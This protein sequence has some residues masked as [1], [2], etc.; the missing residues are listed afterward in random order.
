MTVAEA[1]SSRYRAPALEKGLQILE[2]LARTPRPLT[3][4]QLSES[5]ERSKGEIFRMVQVLEAS[6]YIA[7]RP[8]EEGYALTNRLFTLGMEQP[9]VRDLIGAA[10][11]L[12]QHLATEIQ[13]SCH[14][15]VASREQIVV[16][17]RVESPGEVGFAVRFGARRPLH[18]STSGHVLF[19]FQ[20]ATDQSAWLQMLRDH[21]PDL[22]EARLLAQAREIS[23]QGHARE[24]SAYIDGVTD[25]S[26]PL[27]A[28]RVA[29]AALTVPYVKRANEPSQIEQAA[30]ALS[31]TAEDI[32]HTL[33]FGNHAAITAR[34]TLAMRAPI[35]P[36]KSKKS[37][38][39]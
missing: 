11:P 37:R 33:D 29:I 23:N 25:L 15:A 34:A 24:P 9:P 28:N 16:I 2:L 7:R 13:Q 8:G 10:L 4:S 1:E 26:A 36:A 38:P 21:Y 27:I 19:A 31:R 20:T 18:Q 12:M 22:D 30:L 32:S 14:L 35:A 39:A 6:G 5:L 17:A 3:M